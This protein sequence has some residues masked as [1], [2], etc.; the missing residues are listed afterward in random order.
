MPGVGQLTLSPPPNTRGDGR[1][2][3]RVVLKSCGDTRCHLGDCPGQHAAIDMLWL[4][5]RGRQLSLPC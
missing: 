2:V 1:L 5:G 3:V 4:T